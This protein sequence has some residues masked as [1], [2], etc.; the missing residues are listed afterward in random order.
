MTW[1]SFLSTLHPRVGLSSLQV[2]RPSRM[3]APSALHGDAA[4]FM[5]PRLPELLSSTHSAAPFLPLEQTGPPSTGSWA[6][7]PGAFIRALVQQ[8]PKPLGAAGSLYRD[9]CR[10]KLADLLEATGLDVEFKAARGAILTDVQG[11]MLTD[12][13]G[14]FGAVLLGHNP[15]E[16]KRLAMDLLQA[17]TPIHSQVSCHEAAG[18]LARRLSDL[19]PGG[20]RYLTIFSN[21]GTEAV[22]AAIKHAYKV[23]LDR[24]R[25]RFEEIARE[26]SELY[27]RLEDR[28][29]SAELP[30]GKP[31][32]DFRDDLDQHNLEQFEA[33]QRHPVAI[34]FLG[35][36]H[37]KTASSLKLTYNQSF[38]ECFEGLSA[39]EGEFVDPWQPER[40]REIVESKACQFL[41][42]VVRGNQITLEPAP[43]TRVMACLIEPIQGEGGILPLP[44]T[45]LRWIAQHHRGL[46]LPLIVDEIQTGCGRTGRFLALEDTPLADSEPEYLLLSKA[47]GGGLVKIGATLIRADILDPDFGILHSSTFGEDDFSCRIALGVLDILT[48]NH[49]AVLQEVERKGHYLRR[50]LETLW[51]RY[52][53]LVREVRGRGL[54]MGIEFSDLAG[55]S[56]FFR[57]AGRQGILSILLSSY[58]L[59][60][61]HLRVLGPLT[62]LLKGNPGKTRRSVL[63]LQ[64]PVV[65]TEAEIDRL[66][67]ALDEALAI[68]RANDEAML[69]GH[70]LGW[71]PTQH[72]R[73]SPR[74]HPN[75]W[76]VE[77]ERLDIDAR[78]GFIIHPTALAQVRDYYFPSLAGRPVSDS[79]LEAWWN[80]ISRFLEPAHVRREVVNAHGF[81]LESNLVMVPYLP[82][83]LVG[84]RF[85]RHH[86]EVRD[87]IQDAVTVAKEL[88]DDNIP[89]S[90]VG[91][92]AY[93]SIATANGEVLNDH[94]MAVTTGNAYTAALTLEGIAHAA[95]Q[96]GLDLA[97]ARVGVVGAG[98][99]IGQILSIFLAGSC[100]SLALLGSHREDSQLRLTATREACLEQFHTASSA[101]QCGGSAHVEATPAPVISCHAD[102]SILSQ[103]D[104]VILATSCPTVDLLKPGQLKPGAIVCCTSLP[105]NLSEEFQARP[106]LL[107]FDGGL[108]R[109]PDDSQLNFVGLPQAG[110]AFGCLSEAL[111]LGFEGYNHSFCKGRVTVA[112]V[113]RTREMAG[114]HGFSLGALC[115]GGHPL[116]AE[117]GR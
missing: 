100:G 63:R 49:N 109:L 14:G 39:I 102:A 52:P 3:D 68:V 96:A 110:L 50:G 85:R 99:N 78:I 73:T 117:A 94:E 74:L 89:V 88:G 44:E 23:H 37:G 38:R 91:L 45:T 87:K 64:P 13:V 8:R 83:S 42:P 71:V 81:A 98:G 101:G 104:V 22:E 16:L 108:A 65:I 25:Q 97:Q 6:T 106:D 103:C 114:L 46:A 84:D 5:I 69:V 4:M 18:E 36:F 111:L 48:R 40:L 28:E 15:L 43:L 21:S 53:D 34:A 86:K 80:R 79:A 61:H 51:A 1:T 12:F 54:M 105:S 41:R 55:Q 9:H 92:G 31:L 66:I 95:I 107:A 67:A 20:A 70:L 90:M 7:G 10:P 11:R 47:L 77:E 76:P 56:P 27:H 30:G 17:D 29:L 59:H 93:T 72:E 35:S 116:F 82:S 19:V 58:L 24:V 57:A 113:D 62:T 26:T 75:V 115:L 33:F 60:H 112:Q 2:Y 32:V